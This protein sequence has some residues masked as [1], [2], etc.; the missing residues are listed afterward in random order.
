M[1]TKKITIVLLH[2]S[3]TGVSKLIFSTST[4]RNCQRRAMCLFYNI[5][6]DP[7]LRGDF[8]SKNTVPPPHPMFQRKTSRKLLQ[9]FSE[10]HLWGG[11]TISLAS[12]PRVPEKSFSEIS[13]KFL[14]NFS[15]GHLWGGGVL[16]SRSS[17]GGGIVM[18]TRTNLQSDYLRRR[19][20][21]RIHEWRL[22][23]VL[24]LDRDDETAS[25]R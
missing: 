12:A 24:V 1:T 14:G 22:S 3:S 19:R 18:Q 4:E 5:W 23:V 21:G 7:T 8:V 2:S 25:T 6:N 16:S 10:I 13:R 20:P 11:C 17:Y 9:K 15:E